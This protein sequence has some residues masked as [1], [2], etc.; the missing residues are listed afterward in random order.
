MGLTSW[1]GAPDGKIVRRDVTVG[2]N[3]LTREEMD[4][5]GRVVNAFLDLAESRARR[6]IPMTMEDWASRLDAFLNLDDRAILGDAGTVSK[7][8]AEDHA[9]SE[10]EKFRVLQDRKYVSDFDRFAKGVLEDGDES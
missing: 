4:D 5:M 1:E 6:R 3:Y 8:Q 2:K 7:T 10:F 9:L